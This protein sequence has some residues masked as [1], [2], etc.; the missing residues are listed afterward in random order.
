MNCWG[1]VYSLSMFY[2]LNSRES[3]REKDIMI[4]AES[5]NLSGLP[6]TEFPTGTDH[7]D[8]SPCKCS[9]EVCSMQVPD[10]ARTSEQIV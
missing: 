3:L 5:F 10:K 6:T 2:N 8:S 9:L 4:N 7:R 1:R